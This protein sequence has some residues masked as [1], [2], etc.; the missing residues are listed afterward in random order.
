[1]K[2]LLVSYLTTIESTPTSSLE[3]E[4]YVQPINLRLKELVLMGSLKIIKKTVSP[5]KNLLINASKNPRIFLSPLQNL[6]KKGKKL[7][8]RIPGQ[9]NIA[10]E[11]IFLEAGPSSTMTMLSSIIRKELTLDIPLSKEENKI[12][13]IAYAKPK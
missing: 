11:T 10:I 2:L 4:L 8:S 12:N 3:A 9:P 1:M 5:L 6:S 13:Q 7:L